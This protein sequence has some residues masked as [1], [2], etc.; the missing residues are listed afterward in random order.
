MKMKPACSAFDDLTLLDVSPLFGETREH[1]SVFDM[2]MNEQLFEEGGFVITGF[3][4]A[5]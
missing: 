3:P 1:I 4:G 2:S 5:E